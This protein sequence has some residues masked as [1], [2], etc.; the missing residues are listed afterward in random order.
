MKLGWSSL[1]EQQVRWRRGLAVAYVLIDVTHLVAG[2]FGYIH[3][4]ATIDYFQ[5]G[6]GIVWL[7]SGVCWFWGIKRWQ[8]RA[9]RSK[10]VSAILRRPGLITYSL[11]TA[12]ARSF[13]DS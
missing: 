11:L 1:N 6:I 5:V 4:R 12:P 8:R 2:V 3:A 10:R 13:C 7:L 9:E